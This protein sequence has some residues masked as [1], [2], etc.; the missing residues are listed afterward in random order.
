MSSSLRD[1]VA[2]D[3][4][5]DLTIISNTCSFVLNKV[6][7]NMNTSLLQMD[8]LRPRLEPLLLFD[9]VIKPVIDIF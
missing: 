9:D 1:K 7:E 4:Q 8:K 3:L 5:K 6:Q 2:K